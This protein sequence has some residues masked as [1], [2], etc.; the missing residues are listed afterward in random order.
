MIGYTKECFGKLTE[1]LGKENISELEMYSIPRIAW[2][3]SNGKEEIN[4]FLGISVKACDT[5]LS[6]WE[7]QGWI[8]IISLTERS[9]TISVNEESLK[10][11]LSTVLSSCVLI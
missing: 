8:D 4:V 3:L 9:V 11:K 6:K 5:Y 7:K 2:D 1:L 10:R